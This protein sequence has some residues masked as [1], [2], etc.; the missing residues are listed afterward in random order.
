MPAN[1]A[2]SWI[3]P[4]RW[5]AVALLRST[6]HDLSWRPVLTIMLLVLAYCVMQMVTRL[7]AIITTTGWQPPLNLL[8]SAEANAL[9]VL[10]AVRMAD[11]VVEAG[12]FRWS[13]YVMAVVAGVLA[14]TS[15]A[16]LLSQ[17]LLG[18][19]TA[20][21]M[22]GTLERLAT[23]AF[24]HV[25]HA[26]P[27]SGMALIV[28]IARRRELQRLSALAAARRERSRTER[29]LLEANLAAMQARVEPGFLL[30]A[31]SRVERLYAS[32]GAAGD[33][34]LQ[35]LA[36]Y[37]RAA[38]PQMRHPESSLRQELELGRAYVAVAA[39][40]DA[41]AFRAELDDPALGD[42]RL[43]PMLVLPL[44]G[45]ALARERCRTAPGRS[46]DIRASHDGLALDLEL[47]TSGTAFAPDTIDR[48]ALGPV[49]R[50]LDALYGAAA[51]LRF[52]STGAGS[53]ATLR[54]PL[55]A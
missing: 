40:G 21:V 45:H 6:W 52:R 20:Y 2:A 55:S 11:R 42:L 16:W 41:V 10:F 31:L 23:F 36:R 8:I 32:D 49:Q 17:P 44:L 38:I 39:G 12:T 33:A 5:R 43:P 54:L 15:V 18:I 29:S 22:P 37:L 30:D 48:E 3:Q 13:P 51:S 35:D 24:R 19:R 27:V 26:L 47:R 1:S 25:T 53:V 34:M 46:L 14:G 7:P 28:Y 4:S 50:R 9:A